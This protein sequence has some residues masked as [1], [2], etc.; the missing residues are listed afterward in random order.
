MDT[1]KRLCRVATKRNSE[2]RRR[3]DSR[4]DGDAGR[5]DIV[6]SFVFAKTFHAC[7]LTVRV[8]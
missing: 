5:G 1:M 2:I 7:R 4:K 8:L 3:D 6:A